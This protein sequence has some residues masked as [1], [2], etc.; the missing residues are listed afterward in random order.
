MSAKSSKAAKRQRLFALY[1]AN[2]ALYKPEKQAV[3]VCPL[4][5]REHGPDAIRADS[6]TV[7]LA[8]VYPE[9]CGGRR[10][11][12]TC[13]AHNSIAGTKFDAS[14]AM[15]H[16][17][18]EAIASGKPLRGRLR[19]PLDTI[20]LPER[21][22]SDGCHAEMGVD[23][24]SDGAGLNI[25]VDGG[26]TNPKWPRVLEE[27][28]RRGDAGQMEFDLSWDWFSQER[29]AVSLLYGAYLMLFACYG[30]E[31]VGSGC[32]NLVRRWMQDS[33]VAPPVVLPVPHD[34]SPVWSD[35]LYICGVYTTSEP[36]EYRGLA[37][38]LPSP[39]K[40]DAVRCVVLPGLKDQT[41][42]EYE[43]LRGHKGLVRGRFQS[44][45]ASPHRLALRGFK[46][47]LT[48]R[49]AGLPELDLQ[50]IA[51]LGTVAQFANTETAAAVSVDH[52]ARA[53]SVP[54]A[55]AVEL[56]RGVAAE[57][58]VACEPSPEQIEVAYLTTDGRAWVET[59]L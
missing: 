46:W 55:A 49:W 6:L 57:G 44:F 11:T 50:L 45:T 47:Y 59:H 31:F 20:S 32:G 26:R 23:I 16:R 38:L 9:A 29:A 53:M 13:K 7:D 21:A 25:V 42:S 15:E 35:R 36:L 14:L 3:F 54:P 18:T 33:D 8:H 1:S 39:R 43:V 58:H 40:E 37:V 28:L 22:D 17:L 34:G 56:L 41:M 52:V 27:R 10:L 51:C 30:Y 5:T 24:V 19:V 12:L 2:L 48:R 4:C